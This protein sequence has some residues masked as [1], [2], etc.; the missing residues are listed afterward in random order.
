MNTRKISLRL[1]LV[2][3][4]AL[5]SSSNFVSAQFTRHIIW[6]KNKGNNTYS[7]SNPSSFLSPRSIDRRTRFTISIDSTDLPVS[8]TYVTQIR[9]IS[10]VTI[11]NISK[12]LNAICI[13]SADVTA[14]QTIQNLPF[15]QQVAGL[16]ARPSSTGKIKD[17][18]IREE[19]I[20]PLS[21][22]QLFSKLNGDFYNYGNNASLEV[23][24]HRAEFLHNIGLRGA[25]MQVAVL[26]GGFYN[27]NTLPAFDSI[28]R[29]GQVLGTW[30]FVSRNQ[31]VQ[32][33]HPHGMQ[34]LSTI[35]ANLP[36][37]FVGKAPQASF[38][39]YRTEDVNS[40]YPIEE[41]NWVCGAER[42]DSAGADLISS[43]LGYYDFDNPVFN[44]TYQQ[45]NGR[46]TISVKGADLAAKKGM[47]VFNSAGNEGNN[48]WRY[49]ITPADGDSVIAVGAVNSAGTVASF[50]SYGPSGDGR[51]KPE[52]AS[53]G[54]SAVVQTTSGSI[55]AANGTSFACPNM[56]GLATCLWQG[57]PEFNNMKILD[58][59]KKAASRYTTP[60]DRIGYGIPDLKNAFALLLADYATTTPMLGNC[61]ATI[62]WKSKDVSAM[63]YIVERKLPNEIAYRTLAQPYAT[64]GGQ[65]TNK[66]YSYVDRLQGVAAGQ[67]QYRISQV[68]DTNFTSKQ[69]VLLD[70]SIVT[71][72]TPCTNTDDIASILWIYPNPLTSSSKEKFVINMLEP[73]QNLAI[74]CH[75]LSGRLIGLY[76]FSK[77]A[78]I[79][80][81]GELPFK[82]TSSGVYVLTLWSDDTKLDSK[83]WVVTY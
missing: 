65:L 61:E 80:T 48:S 14:L 31:F 11:L 10:G 3:I 51:I 63:Q 30:D 78:G 38:Y 39:L 42:A 81:N 1:W 68:I 35:A 44:Y 24:L 41:F 82:P 69:T 29:N 23:K 33:D 5:L 21:N 20:F 72:T 67:V 40:E 25:G 59:L 15:V 8:S 32:D 74:T 55:G 28:N 75:D 17:K 47:L 6:L 34:C 46:T 71:L 18:F 76:R 58:A 36:G 79:Y 70:S 9:N 4:L 12:W 64:G 19:D 43:S 60:N 77:P 16:A 50:S 26:D 56:A 54:L 53:V 62:S 52:L 22:Q 13:Q 49:I 57:F 83:E 66:T 7:I 2:L 37:Q 27:Y 73:K 45:M